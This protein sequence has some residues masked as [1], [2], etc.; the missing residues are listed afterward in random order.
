MLNRILFL[1]TG[2]TTLLSVE[3][4]ADSADLNGAPDPRPNIVFFISDDMSWEDFG[5]YGHP[6]IQTPNVDRLADQGMRFDNAYLTT[7]SCSPSRCSII[8]GR[9]PHNTGAPELHSKLPDDQLRFPELLRQAGYYTVLSGKNHMFSYEDRAFDLMTRGG[10]ASGSEDWLGIVQERPK[11]KP[12]FF[13]FASYDG[14]R[15]WHI[16]DKAP[17]YSPEDVVVP[18]YL[19]D[20]P[21]VREDLAKYYHEVSRY[22]HYIGVVTE[23]LK[24]QG[25]LDNTL[26]VVATDNGRPFPRDKT[27]LYDSGIKTPWVVHYPA[28]ID[29]PAA[30]DSLISVIDLSATCLEL[31]GLDIPESVQ[32]RSFTPILKDPDSVVREVV[33]AEHNWHVYQSHERMVR[34]DDYLYIKNNYPEEQNLGHE[35]DMVYLSGREL[36]KAHAAGETLWHQ[37]QVFAHPFPE[38]Q[39]FH[40]SR[41]PNQLWNIVDEPAYAAKLQQ[42]RSLLADWTEQT[43]DTIPENPTPNR[44]EPPKIVDGEIIPMGKKHGRQNPHAEF[45]GAASNA[46]EIN[47]PGPIKIDG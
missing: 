17:V 8:T 10:G 39:L 14:H 6:S 12:F 43:G 45:P 35:S 40:V 46:T 29:E 13:Y 27:Y 20:T 47:H 2:F 44:R 1:V 11:D 37:Q 9:Y 41:D 34:F 24:R 4:F 15:A 33:F 23:E 32:G 26:I 3:L 18:P 28:M 42:A 22:D 31:A 30:T 25:V 7:S 16:D 5:C 19:V 36:W 38:E 21:E